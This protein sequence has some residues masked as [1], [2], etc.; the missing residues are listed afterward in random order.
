MARIEIPAVIAKVQIAECGAIKGQVNGYAITEPDGKSHAAGTLVYVGF[1]GAID[2]SDGLYYGVNRF[3]D[4]TDKNAKRF[5]S[6]PASINAP[7]APEEDD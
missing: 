5:Q 2:T 4:N 6:L 1:A 3:D 7:D